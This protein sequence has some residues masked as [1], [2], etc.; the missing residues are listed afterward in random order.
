MKENGYSGRFPIL[1][2]TGVYEPG[3]ATNRLKSLGASSMM[4]KGFTP[5]QI[6]HRINQLLFSEKAKERSAP[7]VPISI[8]V[9]FTLGDA[10]KT[11]YLLNISATG[12]FLHTSMGILPGLSLLLK[13][14]LPG[15]DMVFDVRGVVRWSTSSS[16]SKSLLGGAGVMFT[17]IKD[18]HKEE[19]KRFVEKEIERFDLLPKTD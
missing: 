1:V 2:V 19:L 13:F 16:A 17:S 15:S 10:T 8:P 14:S 5:E 18:E 3:E 6:I 12:L 11:G 9:D 4:T 7:R